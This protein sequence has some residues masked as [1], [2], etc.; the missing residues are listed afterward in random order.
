MTA[1]IARMHL[2]DE[3]ILHALV[4]RRRN[5]L[6]RSLRALTH[7]GDAATTITAAAMLLRFEPRSV[8]ARAAFALAASH[9]AVQAIKRSVNRPRPR[10]PGGIESL[11]HAPDRFSFPSGHA[12]ASLSIALPLATTLPLPAA[13]GVL[14]LAALVGISR[15][16]LGVHYPG[17]VAAG[18]LL[19]AAGYL[20]APPVLALLARG[21]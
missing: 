12:A 5:W 6:D 17:D 21:G 4:R 1:W 3:A 15:S 13:G 9:L 19:A 20:A 8:G 18:W 7:L 10:L 11:V 14:G 2:R 16:Y